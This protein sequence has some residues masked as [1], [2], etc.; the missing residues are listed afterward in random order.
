MWV[1]V[2]EL[3]LGARVG[4]AVVQTPPSTSSL[5]YSKKFSPLTIGLIQHMN[6]FVLE[7]EFLSQHD[8]RLSISV[9]CKLFVGNKF[10]K[11]PRRR[12]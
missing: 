10:G 2:L 7:E 4:P 1:L 8:Y 12:R 5:I 6:W 11:S 9:Q 3:V